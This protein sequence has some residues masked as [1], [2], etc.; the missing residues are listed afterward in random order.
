[1]VEFILPGSATA[2][3]KCRYLSVMGLAYILA[4]LSRKA[5]S[6]EAGGWP[7]SNSGLGCDWAFPLLP[8]PSIT[9]P[10]DAEPRQEALPIN[11]K[12]VAQSFAQ[13]RNG[14]L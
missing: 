1:M 3:K 11:R 10:Q 14:C 13:A 12:N 8:I 7:T 5:K 9:T 6:A 2:F 4:P